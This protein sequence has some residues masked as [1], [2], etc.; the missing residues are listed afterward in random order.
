M[1]LIVTLQQPHGRVSVPKAETVSFVFLLHVRHAD[2]QHR[3]CSVGATHGFHIGATRFFGAEWS[4][5][6]QLPAVLQLLDN[7]WQ[8][9]S[10]V[11]L[12]SDPESVL[13][14]DANSKPRRVVRSQMIFEG[15]PRL[16]VNQG[17]SHEFRRD[18]FQFA[19]KGFVCSRKMSRVE[20]RRSDSSLPVAIGGAFATPPHS[21][22]T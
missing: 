2:F 15:P 13:A 20:K 6:R 19:S 3:R 10:T 9:S 16:R 12:S 4:V 1:E 5:G 11:T 7:R 14:M 18:S 17:I 22:L 8:D 21:G